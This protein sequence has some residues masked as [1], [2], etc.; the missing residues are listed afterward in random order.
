MLRPICKQYTTLPDK[1]IRKLE[2]IAEGLTVLSKL[3]KADIFIDCPTGINDA[4]IVVAEANP[5]TGSSYTQSVVG[6]YAY[7]KNEPAVLRT[8]ETGLPSRDYKALTQ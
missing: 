8:L 5:E 3:L 1:S 4:A 2:K 6:Q 7:R